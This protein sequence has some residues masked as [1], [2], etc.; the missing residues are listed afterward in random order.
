MQDASIGSN[1][2]VEATIDNIGIDKNGILG[3]G[4]FDFSLAHVDLAQHLVNIQV[5]W[6]NI[7]HM[8]AFLGSRGEQAMINITLD[9]LHGLYYLQAD[10]FR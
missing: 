3:N 7:D 6:R 10:V 2:I 1:S 4:L 9:I 8:Q 5:L